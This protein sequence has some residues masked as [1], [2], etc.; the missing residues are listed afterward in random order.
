MVKH[1]AT[2]GAALNAATQENIAAQ[3]GQPAMVKYLATAGVDV[4]AAA[5]DGSTPLY[6]AAQNSRLEW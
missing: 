4:N 3:N 2:A 6:V 1:L 5:K